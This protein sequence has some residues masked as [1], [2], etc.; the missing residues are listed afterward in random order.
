[1]DPRHLKLMETHTLNRELSRGT[2]VMYYDG[3]SWQEGL[4]ERS[5]ATG[6]ALVKYVLC[7]FLYQGTITEGQCDI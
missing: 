5:N 4:V 6:A 1:M 7:S 2:P 3:Q